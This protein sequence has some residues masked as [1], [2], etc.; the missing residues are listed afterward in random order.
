MI[1]INLLP[2][3][4]KVKSKGKNLSAALELKY[5]PSIIL[6]I[7]GLLVFIH[8]SLAL[9]YI[10]R[11][12]QLRILNNRW[13]VLMPQRKIVEEFNKEYT[14][15]SEDTK[16]I[17]DLIDKR[18]S[19][20]QKLNRL[21]LD[22]PVGL[23]FNNIA[24]T[25]ANFNLQ[26]SAISMQKEEMGLIRKLIDNLKSDAPFFRDLNSLELSSVQKKTIAGY[27]VT[28]FTLIGT[29]KSK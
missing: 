13:Q 24:V 26:G 23:W 25:S 5:L 22:L 9:V 27:E 8:L 28:D 18:V 17:K 14:I 1:E 12:N 29:L 4:L 6:S 10:A 11:N 7:L 19:W 21:S 2:H 3:E 15:F 20:S 16:A